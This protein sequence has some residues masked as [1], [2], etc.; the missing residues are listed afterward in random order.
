MEK[1]P[2]DGRSVSIVTINRNDRD[3]LQRTM[4]SVF[5]QTN[6]DFEYVVIDGGS[7]DGSAELIAAAADRIDYWVSERDRGIYD[8][9]NKG[10]ARA[11]GEYILF[12]NSGDVIYPGTLESLLA[13]RAD[14]WGT[15]VVYGNIVNATT[16]KLDVARDITT[17]MQR[18]AF[19]HQAV[20]V[21]GGVQRELRF[22]TSF[23]IA[24]DYDM[25]VRAYKA[26][27][28][29]HRTSTTF[30][31]YDATGV[32]NQKFFRTM[33]EFARSLWRNH[34]GLGRVRAVARYWWGRRTFIAYLLAVSILGDV[35]YRWL[36]EALR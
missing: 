3:G 18:E 12:L 1:G 28:T 19:I 8:A 13:R 31:E 4:D 15:D 2:G 7:S 36:R 35:R 9:M 22:D 16:G 21:R 23:R 26:G 34:R 32:S 27:R 33:N 6:R 24:A 29:F 11:T 10:A 5:A 20:L 14:W 17:L 30:G 25:F